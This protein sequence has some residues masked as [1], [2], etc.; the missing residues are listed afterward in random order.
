MRGGQHSLVQSID[1]LLEHKFSEE[2]DESIARAMEFFR[3]KLMAT[4]LYVVLQDVYCFPKLCPAAVSYELL[5]FFKKRILNK[6]NC[7]SSI[8]D[9]IGIHK[10]VVA[11]YAIDPE[12]LSE[13][14]CA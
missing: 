11:E 8:I 6:E 5:S 13:W 2:R 1:Q 9:H 4:H 12:S 3:V 7:L 14:V 10:S